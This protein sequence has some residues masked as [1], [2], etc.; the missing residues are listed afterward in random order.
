MTQKFVYGEW[1]LYITFKTENVFSMMVSS[2]LTNEVY[3]NDAIEL[4]KIKKD[5]VIA[6]MDQKNEKNLRCN[7]SVDY[8]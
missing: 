5:T 8:R 3:S 1:A 6:T 2:N 7:G 4:S